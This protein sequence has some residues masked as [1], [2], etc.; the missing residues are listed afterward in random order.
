MIHIVHIC[1]YVNSECKT[2]PRFATCEDKPRFATCNFNIYM[3]MVSPLELNHR[4]YHVTMVIF[5]SKY[6][7]IVK[8]DKYSLTNVYLFVT[9]RMGTKYTLHN[10]LWTNFYKILLEEI[11]S[12]NTTIYCLKSRKSNIHHE[13]AHQPMLHEMEGAWET[14]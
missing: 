2:W 13:A 14:T 6:H 8:R 1:C 4:A 11:F 5:V 12:E 7:L 9:S 10:M 3:Y